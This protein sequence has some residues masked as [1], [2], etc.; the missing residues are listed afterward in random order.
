MRKWI[1]KQYNQKFYFD[2]FDEARRAYKKMISNYLKD[3]DAYLNGIIFDLMAFFNEKYDKGDI[4]KKEA[5]I[6]KTLEGLGN[7]LVTEDLQE[8][9]KKAKEAYKEDMSIYYYKT[10][11]DRHNKEG[12]DIDI[13]I[14]MSN[15]ILS[16]SITYDDI[17][18][19]IQ[20]FHTNAFLLERED[21]DYSF[22]GNAMVSV[23][24]DK[25]KLNHMLFI[26]IE[27]NVVEDA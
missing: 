25:N 6:V 14:K 5:A 20:R 23:S 1:I 12:E 11:I 10:V 17:T 4:S 15:G 26:D 13:N 18:E 7:S 16:L 8:A 22:K 19:L 3:N 24:K 9:M 27:L 21:V 2:N